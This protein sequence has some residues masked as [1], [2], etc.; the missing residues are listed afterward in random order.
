MPAWYEAFRRSFLTFV[1]RRGL[2]TLSMIEQETAVTLALVHSTRD[3]MVVCTRE[4]ASSYYISIMQLILMS[5][6]V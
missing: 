4:L 5:N 2:T 3:L 6:H 1:A